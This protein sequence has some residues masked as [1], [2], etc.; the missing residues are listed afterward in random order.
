MATVLMPLFQHW[1]DKLAGNAESYTNVTA[2][3]FAETEH[4]EPSAEGRPLIQVTIGAHHD[5]ARELHITFREGSQYRQ[6]VNLAPGGAP[7]DGSVRLEMEPQDLER[8]YLT[9]GRAIEMAKRV[10]LC[11]SRA[12]REG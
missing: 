8:L 7:C 4:D 11:D 5:D 6:V 9:L 1:T 10:G 12:G 3:V 2:Q